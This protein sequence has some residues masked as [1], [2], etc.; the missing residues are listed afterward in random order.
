MGDNSLRSSGGSTALSPGGTATGEEAAFSRLVGRRGSGFLGLLHR[1]E[2]LRS[3]FPRSGCHLRGLELFVCESIG[4]IRPCP[5]A[6]SCLV[7]VPRRD[8]L[9]L[10]WPGGPSFPP[11]G[12]TGRSECHVRQPSDTRCHGL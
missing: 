11:R 9:S 4:H 3:A 10:L 5:M 8:L 1:H 2:E 12:E 7:Y 6:S